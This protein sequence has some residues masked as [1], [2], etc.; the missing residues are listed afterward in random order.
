MMALKVVGVDPSLTST[1]LARVW[2][3]ADGLRVDT[4]T[5][6]SKGS[7]K[8]SWAS[9]RGRILSLTDQIMAA[10]APVGKGTLVVMESPSYGSAS[11]SVH[12]RAGLW[13]AL[14]GAFTE[15]GA[16]VLPVSPSQR[17][18]YATGSGRADKDRVLA[19]VVRRYL[20]VDVRGNDEADALVFAAMGARLLG[21]PVE[22]SLPKVNA[23]A[24]DRVDRRGVP[25][26]EGVRA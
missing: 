21:M 16:Y 19:A 8:A 3:D 24:L 5:V 1:G 20:S 9:R 11:T 14:Y 18:K 4:D 10:C 17:M 23:S 13:W 6:T 25:G 12:D 22:E 7:T 15:A 26:V 2:A